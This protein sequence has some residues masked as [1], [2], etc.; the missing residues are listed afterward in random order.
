MIFQM[1]IWFSKIFSALSEIEENVSNVE[2]AFFKNS[3]AFSNL[4]DTGKPLRSKAINSDS[5]LFAI[6]LALFNSS[7]P[8][9]VIFK[10]EEALL[11][12]GS[13]LII[14]FI[15]IVSLIRLIKICVVY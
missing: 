2:S 3:V 12:S 14:F 7:K 8:V 15:T 5:E 10:I 9:E 13:A 4:I 6:V 1:V 11:S